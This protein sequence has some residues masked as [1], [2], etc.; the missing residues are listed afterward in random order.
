MAPMFATSTVLASGTAALPALLPALV[1]VPLL[2]AV[3]VMLL[4]SKDESTPR[5]VALM[6]AMVT[7]ALSLYLLTQFQRGEAGYQFE[8]QATWVADWGM[9]WHLG[10]DGISLFMVVLTAV[11]YPLSILGAAQVTHP[12]RTT[13]GCRS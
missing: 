3:L 10:V 12:R 7:A 13:P 4:P 11:L 8:V 9:S 6:G 1:L 5:Q 2:T